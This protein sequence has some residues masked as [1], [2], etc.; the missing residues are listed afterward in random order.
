M[1]DICIY[2]CAMIYQIAYNSFA[3]HKMTRDIVRDILATSRLHNMQHGITGLLLIKND[4]VFQIIEGRQTDIEPLYRRIQLDSRHHSVS[5]L[6][7]RTINTRQFPEWSM[8][9][10][11]L[12][13]KSDN[14]PSYAFKLSMETLCKAIPRSASQDLDPFIQTYS[15]VAGL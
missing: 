7:E 8:G 11:D 15:K 13:E 10:N 9:Y 1:G 12:T 14:L 3:T 5:T 6:L 2:G 4:A